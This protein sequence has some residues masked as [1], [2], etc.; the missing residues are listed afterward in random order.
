MAIWK[1][2]MNLFKKIKILLFLIILLSSLL[3]FYKLGSIPPALYTDEIDQGYNAYSVMQNGKDEHGSFLPVSLRSF[4]DWKPPIQSYLMIPF[5]KLFGLNEISVRLPSVISGILSVIL[6]YLLVRFL[7]HNSQSSSKTALLAAF[8]TAISPW[9]IFQSRC[10][11]L[12]MI[13]LVCFQAG[14]LFFLIGKKKI[15]Y[16][17]SAIFFVISIYSYYGMRVIVPVFLMTLFIYY[18]LKKKITLQNLGIFILTAFFLMLPLL[19]TFLHQREVVL[20]RAQTVSVFYDKGV[21]LRQWELF[22][23]DGINYS[24]LL[25]RFFH[26]NLYLY[27]INIL[28]RYFSHFD[29]RYLF[30]IGDQA[31]PFQ[32]PYMGILNA[33]DLLLIPVGLYSVLKKRKGLIILLSWGMLAVVPAALTFMTPASNRTFNLAF[34]LMVFAASGGIYIITHVKYKKI[35]IF[36]LTLVYTSSFAYFSYQYFISLPGDF[37]QWWNY[38]WKEAVQYVGENQQKYEN[39]IVSDKNGMPYIYFLFYGKYDPVKYQKEAVRNYV[40]DQFGFEHVDGFGKYSFPNDLDW[41]AVKQTPMKNTLYLIP[42]SQSKN[43]NDFI[44]AVKD[45]K[46]EIIL[47]FFKYE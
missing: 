26:N 23:Q 37:S 9:H 31:Q 34:P 11:M 10:A 16:A 27:G 21:K 41:E 13:A 36:C 45:P 42:A 1:K 46:G 5:I 12:V 28:S 43:D 7:L 25:S 24:T 3:R 18:L 30:I 19:I 17:F 22:T 40:P 38:G 39:I 44:H 20:G 47:K 14:T 15:Y 35:F 32:I 4:G 8:F 2:Y 33:G 29:A 6:T